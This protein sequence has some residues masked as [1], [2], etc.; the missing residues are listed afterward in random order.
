[1]CFQQVAM[2]EILLQAEF[3]FHERMTVEGRAIL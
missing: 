2:T 1:M 3:G